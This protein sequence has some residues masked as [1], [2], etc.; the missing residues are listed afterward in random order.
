MAYSLTRPQLADPPA[1]SSLTPP[2]SLQ[3]GGG[4]GP[5]ALPCLNSNI[6]IID[7]LQTRLHSVCQLSTQ[8]RK[9]SFV[10]SQSVAALAADWGLQNLGFLTLTFADH[11]TCP[12]EAQRRLNSLISNVI[13]P[14]YREYL[15][16]FERQKSGRIHYHFLVVLDNDIRSGFNFDQVDQGIYKSANNYLRSEWSYWRHT[17][18][19]YGFGRTELM[20]I[21]STTEAISKYVGKYISKHIENRKDNDKGVR[22]VRYSQGA[23]KIL[24]STGDY[25]RY[26]D[27]TIKKGARIGNTRFSFNSKGSEQW[28][29][30]VATLAAIIEKDTGQPCKNLDDLKK[31]LGP[32][33]AYRY[34]DVILK[35]PVGYTLPV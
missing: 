31:H 27:G 16:V 21:K 4:D 17:S 35:L 10:L 1:Y 7:P 34:R 14:R 25:A 32:R 5:S 18:K 30:K 9:T 26:P 19:S 28:R 33:W 3:G 2:R 20:P 15:G 11:V 22:L 12:R 24:K 23:K 6:S 13:K 29:L 8:H